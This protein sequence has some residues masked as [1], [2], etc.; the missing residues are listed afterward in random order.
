MVSLILLPPLGILDNPELGRDTAV[1]VTHSDGSSESTLGTALAQYPKIA[2]ALHPVDAPLHTITLPPLPSN[3]RDAALRVKLEDEVLMDT[4]Q[5]TLAVQAVGK[6]IFHV[7]T[8]RTA[9]LTQITTVL[10]SLGHGQRPVVALAAQL[11]QDS[12]QTLGEWTL[13]RDAQGAGAVPT[14]ISEASHG[15]NDHAKP[16]G[17]ATQAFN[18]AYLTAANARFNAT[19]S[20]RDL[21]QRWR[22]VALLAALCA[23]IYVAGTWLHWRNMLALE[24]QAQR[25]IATSFTQ[26]LPNTPMI[27]PVLQ[28]QRASAGG[29][30]LTQA[31]ANLPADWPQGT[32]TQLAWANKRLSVTANASA[33]KLNAAQQTLMTENLA[34]KNIAITWSKP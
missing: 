23:F 17:N 13:Y 29:N 30:A 12:H 22:W 8:V 6:Q 31:L 32:V 2:L 7:C 9:L 34:A 33:L 5:L 19:Q 4:A 14:Q 28:L 11:P 15:V 18:P 10:Q 27:D 1:L 21:W 20:N 25:S 3:R 16:S 24:K 26:A